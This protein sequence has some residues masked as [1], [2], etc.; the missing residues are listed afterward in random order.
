MQ[1]HSDA[2]MRGRVMALYLMIF[3]GGTPLG[4]PDRGLGRSSAFGARWSLVIGGVLTIA[5]VGRRYSVTHGSAVA[6]GSRSAC[7]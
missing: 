3:L 2:G 7:E 6:P 5:G 1:L 4:A